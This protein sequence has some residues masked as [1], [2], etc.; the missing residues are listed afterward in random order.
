M[1]AYENTELDISGSGNYDLPLAYVIIGGLFFFISLFLIV[2]KYDTLNSILKLK[3]RDVCVCRMARAYQQNFVEG[4]STGRKS[5]FFNL[6]FAAWDY[7]I[8]DTDAAKM[9]H[10]SLKKDL[11]VG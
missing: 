6:V 9:K 4:L 8:T 5:P 7:S 2:V 3:Y 11:E 10:L 1:G